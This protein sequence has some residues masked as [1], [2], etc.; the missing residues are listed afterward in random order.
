MGRGK[1]IFLFH[2]P[3]V[4]FPESTL[5]IFLKGLSHEMALAV[6]DMYG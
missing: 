1:I 4:S 2:I 3:Y 6:D 5:G